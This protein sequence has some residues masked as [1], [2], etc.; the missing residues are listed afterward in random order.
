MRIRSGLIHD[1]AQRFPYGHHPGNMRI[2]ITQGILDLLEPEEV[3]GV[4][5]HEI[6]HGKNWDMLLMTVVQLVPLLLFFI[7]RSAL[8]FG[9]R[10]KGKGYRIAVAVSAY[11]LYIAS[12]Y[13]VLWFSRCREYY[14]DR[15]AGNVTGNPGALASAL[16]KIGYGPWRRATRHAYDGGVGKKSS[17]KKGKR[18]RRKQEPV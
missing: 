7:Y 13:V 6:G 4:V 12:E 11:V 3:E 9:G 16:V 8:R 15:F 14:A 18:R 10:G 17:T 2:V 5:A 1:G